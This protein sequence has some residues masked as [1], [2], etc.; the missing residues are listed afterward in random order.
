[1]KSALPE[2]ARLKILME[3]ED[4][5]LQSICS[6][7]G[8]MLEEALDYLTQKYECAVPRRHGAAY[9]LGDLLPAVKG[10]LRDNLRVEI[11]TLVEG[12][13]PTVAAIDLKPMLDALSLIAQTRNV[14]GAHFNT[15]SFELL[16][17]DAMK[18][19]KQVEQLADALVC[20]EHGW[21]S[22]EKSGS[23]WENG[24]GTRRLHPLRKPS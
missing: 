24:G 20:P 8:V 4:P 19:A 5:D 15:L 6:K 7:A 14:M 17:A 16:D 22:R 13:E 12:A 1:M 21:P 2:T 23:Y 11:V 10:K 3:A 9:T 18:F